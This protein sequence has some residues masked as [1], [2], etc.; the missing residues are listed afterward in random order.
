M[1]V[2]PVERG[3]KLTKPAQTINRPKPLSGRRHHAIRPA[4]MYLR[5]IQSFKNARIFLLTP[6]A[7]D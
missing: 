4:T 3:E 2:R 5:V 7:V 1:G 6:D